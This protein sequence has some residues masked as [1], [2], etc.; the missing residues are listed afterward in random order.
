MPTKPKVL[1]HISEIN[2]KIFSMRRLIIALCVAGLAACSSK[3]GSSDIQKEL[4]EAYKCRVLEL[5]EVKK[6]DGA[7][8]GKIVSRD[9]V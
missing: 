3:P 9:V 6:N 8:V 2:M 5:S 1:F 7:E 4:A